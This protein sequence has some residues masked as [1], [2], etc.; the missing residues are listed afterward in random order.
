MNWDAIGA[1]G[2]VVGAIAVV[3][4]LMYLAVQIRAQNRE[5]RLA[6]IHE[7]LNA[8]RNVQSAIADIESC[9]LVVKASED[10]SSL[11]DSERLRTM[12]IIM[13]NLRVWEEAYHQYRG[14]RLDEELWNAF[15]AQ[16]RDIF[17]VSFVQEIWT[18]RKHVFTESFR[19]YVDKLDPGEYKIK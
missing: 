13:P 9:D 5:S 3:V 17:A 8:F 19:Q 16:F 18:L 7:I 14:G 10:F 2:E 1:A 4:S 6:S 15:V 11:S 12:M